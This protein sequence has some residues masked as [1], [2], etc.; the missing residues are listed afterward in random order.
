MRYCDIISS[1]FKNTLPYSL[2]LYICSYL[3]KRLRLKKTKVYRY[4]THKHNKR[5]KIIMY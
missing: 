1:I 4:K 5:D 3:H 2:I